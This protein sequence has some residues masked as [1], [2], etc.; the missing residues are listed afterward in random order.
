MPVTP[1]KPAPYATAGSILDL[2]NRHRDRGLPATVDA[3]VLGRLGI[4][5][6]LIPRTLQALHALDLIDPKTGAPTDNFE[7]LRL[8]AE[9]EFK[10]RLAAWLKATYADVFAF[11]DPSKDGEAR[12]R[13]AFRT[14]NPIGQQERMVMLFQGLCTAAGLMAAKPA[15]KGAPSSPSASAAAAAM[16]QRRERARLA[17]PKRRLAERPDPSVRD[18]SHNS[19]M[20][21]AI[22]GLMASL[23]SPE[24]GWTA[25][26]RDKFIT[27][28]K[29]VLDF[30]IPIIRQKPV[31]QTEDEAA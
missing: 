30:A 7:T 29:A 4:A 18:V 11:V 8:A 27:T 12:I 14:Y 2:I 28:F 22:A 16:P 31:S 1:E 20:P 3:D 19:S 6:T 25:T 9:D 10:D 24:D 5:P 13:D 21:P 15:R 26:E 17:E 23:P